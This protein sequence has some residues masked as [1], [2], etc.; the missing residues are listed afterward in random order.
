MVEKEDKENVNRE[1]E[2]RGRRRLIREPVV[3]V[4]GSN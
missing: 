2:G 3:E 4:V 1:K